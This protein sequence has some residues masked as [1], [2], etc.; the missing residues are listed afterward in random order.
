MLIFFSVLGLSF[1]ILLLRFRLFI[2]LFLILFYVMA[3]FQK[4]Y[5]SFYSF[6]Y[7]P[8][9]PDRK[10]PTNLGGQGQVSVVQSLSNRYLT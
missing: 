10:N 8:G 2:L 3:Y 9:Y 5:I 6:Y 1:I 4:K 7:N